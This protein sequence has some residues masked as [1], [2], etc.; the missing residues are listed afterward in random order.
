MIRKIFI[1]AVAALGLVGCLHDR[2]DRVENTPVSRYD[3][4]YDD[5][6]CGLF[7][8][9][10]D[11]LVAPI[12]YESL[13]FLKRTVE[14]SVAVVLFSCSKDGLEG[15]MCVFEQSNEKMEILFPKE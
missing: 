2:F 11:S 5:T 4:V 8:N 14:D 6:K 9:E 1:F 15:M 7:D 10:A 13:S 3:I 12:E